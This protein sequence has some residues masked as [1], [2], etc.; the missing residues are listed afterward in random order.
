MF[1]MKHKTKDK[2][3]LAKAAVIFRLAE[4]GWV[5]GVPLTEHAKYDLFAEKD[6]IIHTVQVKYT[7]L[8]GERIQVRLDSSWADRNGNH[9]RRRLPQDYSLLAGYTPGVGVFFLT[10]EEIGEIG[11]EI[12]LRLA[13]PKNTKQCRL[14]SDFLSPHGA[15]IARPASNRQVPGASPG[16]GMTI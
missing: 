6:G 2:G 11:G 7:S 8:K 13:K 9:R 14:V 16:E 12:T 4:L 15:M 10:N 5:V 1:T 3:D